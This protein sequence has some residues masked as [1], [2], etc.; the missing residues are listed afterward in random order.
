MTNLNSYDFTHLCYMNGNTFL[1]PLSLCTMN[2]EFQM[3]TSSL[4]SVREKNGNPKVKMN[5]HA[6]CVIYCYLTLTLA[7]CCDCFKIASYF[8]DFNSKKMD[9]HLRIFVNVCEILLRHLAH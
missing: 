3:M 7:E 5:F 2:F 1:S 9:Y 8:V 6:C 4:H